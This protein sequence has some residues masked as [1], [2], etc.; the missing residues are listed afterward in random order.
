[1][2]FAGDDYSYTDTEE[3]PVRLFLQ[4]STTVRMSGAIGGGASDSVQAYYEVIEFL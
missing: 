2:G 4:D 3:L 1:M